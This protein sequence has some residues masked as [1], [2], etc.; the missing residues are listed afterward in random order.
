MG[1]VGLNKTGMCVCCVC[2]QMLVSGGIESPAGL[3]VDWLTRKLY[4]TEA[5]H[6]R[7]EVANLDATMRTI[8]VWNGLD[9][10]RDV[11]VHPGT[12]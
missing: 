10:P 3:A 4:W 12:G 7:I 1:R 5:V 9:K 11:A 6:R 8:L 2:V